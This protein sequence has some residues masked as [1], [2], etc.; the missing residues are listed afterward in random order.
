MPEFRLQGIE[1]VKNLGVIWP[2]ILGIKKNKILLKL[3]T[4]FSLVHMDQT[5]AIQSIQE[6][7]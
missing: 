5:V 3:L 7:V 4:F 1:N 6:V 2:Q